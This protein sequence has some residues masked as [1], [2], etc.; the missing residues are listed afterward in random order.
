MLTETL[1]TS[2]LVVDDQ[3]T[4]V[5]EMCEFLESHGF[6]CIPCFSSSQAIERFNDD[7]TITLV[8]CDLIMPGCDGIELINKLKKNSEKK[9]I[10]HAVLMSAH[11]EKDDMVRALREG[12]SD[13]H[14]K[15]TNPSALIKTLKKLEDIQ[16][17]TKPHLFNMTT[18]SERLQDLATAINDLYLDIGTTTPQNVPN[19]KTPLAIKAT[20]L[21]TPLLCA[22][23]PR[24]K[25]VA[26]LIGIAK[27]NYQISCDLGIT[28]D[29]VKLY[30]SQILNLTKN[31]NRTQLALAI[32]SCQLNLH[33]NK[34]PPER[35]P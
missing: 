27:T 16:K 7:D 6:R 5:E 23:S 12:F 4:I 17:N 22:L 11:G 24:Q 19:I 9:R 29:T 15:P 18:F 34:Q 8:L 26:N 1:K 28:E 33:D 21:N 10:F 32:N 30:V 2:I 13:Y 14:Q 3:A 20:T 35:T 31:T 25:E